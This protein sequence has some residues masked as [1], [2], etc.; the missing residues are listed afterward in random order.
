MKAVDIPVQYAQGEFEYFSGLQPHTLNHI[1]NIKSEH[2]TISQLDWN[3]SFDFNRPWVRHILPFLNYNLIKLTQSLG[4]SGMFLDSVWF[5]RYTTNSFHDWHIHTKHYTGVLYLEY[6]N[7]CPPT[8][9]VFN[10]NQI[11]EIDAKEG[12]IVIFPSFVVHRSPV[13]YSKEQKTIISF[14]LDLNIEEDNY[15][16]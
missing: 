9:L 10:N 7:S 3:E 4:Y 13:N 8:Q 1:E 16:K 2:P 6:P 14:N 5:Q 15:P 12:D 11:I